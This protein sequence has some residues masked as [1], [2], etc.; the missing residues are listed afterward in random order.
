MKNLKLITTILVAIFSMKSFAQVVYENKEKGQKLQ[1]YHMMQM[2]G[3]YQEMDVDRMPDGAD[4]RIDLFL[5]RARFGTKGSINPTVEFQVWYAY[6]FL[7]KDANTNAI[8][9]LTGVNT[10]DAVFQVWDAFVK[11]KLNPKLDITAGF[12]RPQTSRESIRSG[13]GTMSFEKVFSN[14]VHRTYTLGK[15]PGR[16]PGI[17]MSGTFKNEKMGVKYNLGIF[18]A[19][20][21]KNIASLMTAARVSFFMGEEEKGMKDNHFGKKNGVIIGLYGTYQPKVDQSALNTLKF[22]RP[23]DMTTTTVNESTLTGAADPFNAVKSSSMGSDLLINYKGINVKAEYSMASYKNLMGSDIAAKGHYEIATYDIVG[24]YTFAEVGKGDLELTAGYAVV[25]T[26]EKIKLGELSIIDSKY[27][28]VY[29]DTA[30][31]DLGLN[32]YLQ[33]EKYKINL[34]Y[35]KFDEKNPSNTKYKND[36][37]ALGL[38]YQW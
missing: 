38:Q 3:V 16:A 5:R 8:K 34:H 23:D 33:Q 22:S 17:D 35:V 2:W 9:G 4:D 10:N 21:D 27:G 15:G 14:F 7:G 31:T 37:V 29:G 36:Y 6:D 32:Y 26:D 11:I 12:F 20:Q 30:M 13:F 1:I 19:F 28:N 18:N 24:G 25:D